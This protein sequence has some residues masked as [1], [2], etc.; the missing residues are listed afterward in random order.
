MAALLGILTGLLA[1]IPNIG[2][3]F[4]RSDRACRLQRQHDAGYGRSAS[5]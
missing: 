2:A 5:M 3:S 1:F 4:G